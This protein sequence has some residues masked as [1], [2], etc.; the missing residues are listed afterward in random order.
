MSYVFQFYPRRNGKATIRLDR[1]TPISSVMYGLLFI[2]IPDRTESL[3]V[4]RTTHWL[5]GAKRELRVYEVGT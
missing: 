5:K 2:W 1:G 3:P 4:F